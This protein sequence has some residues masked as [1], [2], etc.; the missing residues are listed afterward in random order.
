MPYFQTQKILTHSAV[1]T[2]L[3]AAI[4][5]AENMNV[6]QCI[7]IVDASGVTLG[8]IRMTDS[9]FLSQKSAFAKAKTA[10]SI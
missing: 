2:M 6:P 4:K 5:S 9:K 7:V 3:T 1:I 8:Q 10:A